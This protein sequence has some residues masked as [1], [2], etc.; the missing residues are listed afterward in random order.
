MHSKSLWAVEST[1]SYRMYVSISRTGQLDGRRYLV[2]QIL[3]YA[4]AYQIQFTYM[5]LRLRRYRQHI[6][7]ISSA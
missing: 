3:I 1:I 5:W 2:C 6:G 7:P 4:P